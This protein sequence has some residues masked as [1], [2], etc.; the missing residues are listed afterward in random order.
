MLAP[1]ALVVEDAEEFVRLNRRILEQEGFEVHVATSGERGLMAAREQ[2]F[3]LV[4]VDVALP[5]MDGFD[6]CR[7]LRT[8]SDAY[9]LMVTG[10]SAEVEKIVGF[11]VGADDYVTKPYSPVELSA[12]IAAMRRRPRQPKTGSGSSFGRLELNADARE[13]TVDGDPVAMTRI[14]FD[15]LHVLSGAPRR[16]F[17][18]VQLLET[19]WG[20]AQGDAHVV[21]VHIG[22]LRR[23]LREALAQED[24]IR[25]V[26]GVG[27]KFD[28]ST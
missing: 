6:V 23:K 8:F 21:D 22:N 2:D 16:V 19:V 12:R 13:V 14:E 20:H 1:K 25:T 4:L 26:R 3:E 7:E 18:R 15:L 11:R 28:P 27:Y 9:V 10:R 5:G 24:P 17:S